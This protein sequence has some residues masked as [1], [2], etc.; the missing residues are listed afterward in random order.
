MI[1]NKLTDRNLLALKDAT[2]NKLK[3]HII[4]TLVNDHSTAEERED[5]VRDVLEHGCQSGVC[6]DL[7]YYTDTCKFYER[8]IYEINDLL[9]EIINDTGT[10]SMAE[11][12]PN[13]YDPDDPLCL[14]T[15]NQNLLAWF[16]YEETLRDIYENDFNN[17]L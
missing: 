8:F 11:L 16:G 15:S 13:S 17:E 7:I 14:D 10:D 12:F 5:Y 9:T 4:E 3:Q 6:P 2:N 1:K